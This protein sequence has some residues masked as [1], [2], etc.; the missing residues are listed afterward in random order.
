MTTY[1]LSEIANILGSDIRDDRPIRVLLTDSRALTPNPEEVLFFAL[2]TGKGDGHKYIPELYERGVRAF[3]VSERA[4]LFG[5]YRDAFF[6]QTEDSLSA[7]QKIALVQREKFPFPV[8]GLTGSAGKTT[9]K[10]LLYQILSKGTSLRVSRSPQSYNSALG[11]P[12][13]LW[14]VD[15]KSD[16]ALIE[17]GISEPGE[18]DTLEGLI[19]PEIGLFTGIG[20]AHGENFP[21]R[22]AKAEEK[23]KLFRNAEV[24]CIGTDDPDV[25]TALE[26][27]AD[28]LSGVSIKNWSATDPEADLFVEKMEEFPGDTL[29]RYRLRGEAA[30]RSVTV[31]FHEKGLLEDI[32]LSL[33][34]LHYFVPS[35]FEK[36]EEETRKLFGSLHAPAM[37]ME[38]I[39]GENDTLLVLP[40]GSNAPLEPESLKNALGFIRKRS[41]GHLL[42]HRKPTA[43]VL[44]DELPAVS[45]DDRAMRAGR[46]SAI[47]TLVAAQR[48]DDPVSEHKII[49]IGSG[50]LPFGDILA[51]SGELH[52]FETVSD[53]L[54]W[55]E[56]DRHDETNALSTEASLVLSGHLVL[57]LPPFSA[58]SSSLRS[59]NE[60]PPL[61]HLILEAFQKKSHQTILRVNLTAL[62]SNLDALRT[63]LP[64]RKKTKVCAMIKAFGYG[65]G[66]YEIAKELEDDGVEYLAVAVVDEGKELREKGIR[67]PIIVMNPEPSSF[68]Q[69]IRYRLEPNI[70]SDTLLR[71]FGSTVAA[72]GMKA[73]PVHLSFDTGMHRLG[74]E[75]KDT[76]RLL[77][78]LSDNGQGNAPLK[79]ISIFTHLSKADMPTE[80]AYTLAQL[81]T[82]TRTGEKMK[83]GLPYPFLTHV[84]NTAGL[85]RFPEYAMDMVRMGV[86][87]YGLS[88]LDEETQSRLKSPLKP[89]AS[90]ET[91][92]LQ[93]RH[94]PA[95]A[96]VGYGNSGLLTRPSRIGVI[97]IGYADGLPRSLGRGKVSFITEGGIAVPTVGNICMDATMIDLTDAPLAVEGSKVIL[98]G[99]T[100]EAAIE[101][102][103]KADNPPAGTIHYEVLARL[104]KRITRSYYH[105]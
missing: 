28:M 67:T 8:V 33:L 43:V 13:S 70:Y 62:R 16:I 46:Y 29:I 93:T 25:R 56:T 35:L 95:G 91:V 3:V 42:K 52:L 34:F 18:M 77:Q 97:P 84:L 27:Q 87:L 45:D 30:S 101:R 59:G 55:N 76:P 2:R 105:E 12:L 10:E 74:F 26:R 61:H 20:D 63:L 53:F 23:L 89:V 92:I 66:S 81:E 90:L 78:Y 72:L 22:A 38:V 1:T 19:R 5:T 58:S 100:P 11:V 41:L 103:A 44:I 60:V 47:A 21:S 14:Q 24:L 64:N 57:L 39:D 83:G 104:S 79:V 6:I 68:V 36:G 85:M 73:Y 31:P 94:L 50:V 37:R 99:D 40:W 54:S 75:E 49:G 48:G 32:I 88:P 9:V 69:L 15:T 17:A 51:G 86:G 102:L 65:A 98:F 71:S 80:D 82:I 96:T 7:L 4:D